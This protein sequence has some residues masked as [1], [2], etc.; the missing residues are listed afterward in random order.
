[1]RTLLD[2]Y[3]YNAWSNA[4]VFATCRDTD[5]SR[6]EE[7]AP[8]TFGTIESTLKHLVGVEDA[9]ALML[10][11]ISPEGRGSIDDYLKRDLSWFEQRSAELGEEYRTLL[12]NASDAFYDEPLTVPWFDFSLTKHDGLLQVATHSAQHRA[13]VLSTLGDRGIS[14]PNLDFVVFVQDSRGA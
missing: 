1:M 5:R 9:Y 2:L 11:D 6:L 12:T 14:V 3:A 8:G 10:R 13:Q 4:L 7:R